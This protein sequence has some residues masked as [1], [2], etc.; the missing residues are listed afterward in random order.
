MRIKEEEVLEREERVV[1]VENHFEDS[2]D[3]AVKKWMRGDF[4]GVG[5][6]FPEADWRI[7]NERHLMNYIRLK[8]SFD[9]LRWEHKNLK[10]S[11]AALKASH[12]AAMEKKKGGGEMAKMARR[13]RLRVMKNLLA[14]L[15][16]P[17]RCSNR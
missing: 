17:R 1:K 10:A 13:K 11:H 15:I 2:L 4:E 3:K 14:M 8:S 9:Q 5:E 16:L 6:D 7:K 12:A